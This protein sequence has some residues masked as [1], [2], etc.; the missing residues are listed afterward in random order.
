MAKAAKHAKLAWVKEG[1]A[2]G[3]ERFSIRQSGRPGL[4]EVYEDQ[5]GIFPA[6]LGYGSTIT[7]AKAI[8]QAFAD[9]ET[10]RGEGG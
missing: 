10:L 5:G 6:F 8:A 1:G 9:A 4:W 2:W 3:A 7:A